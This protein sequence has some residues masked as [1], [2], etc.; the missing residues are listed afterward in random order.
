MKKK[1]I[2]FFKLRIW[3]YG[4]DGS[5]ANT[6]M[7]VIDGTYSNQ[8]DSFNFVATVEVIKNALDSILIISI[9]KIN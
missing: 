8:Y 3:V 1:I 2:F 9:S 4:K 6:M 7:N 5:C